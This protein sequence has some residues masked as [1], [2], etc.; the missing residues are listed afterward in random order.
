LT[1]QRLAG[2]VVSK[3]DALAIAQITGDIPQNVNFAIKESVARAMLD[4]YGIEY[5]TE[6]APQGPIDEAAK[7]K[8]ATV[9]IQCD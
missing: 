1:I 2:I 3:L 8:A 4:D 9:Y 7:A 5:I 6:A